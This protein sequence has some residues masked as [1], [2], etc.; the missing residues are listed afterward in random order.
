VALSLTILTSELWMCTFGL[1]VKSR[2]SMGDWVAGEGVFLATHTRLY[3]AL[4][5]VGRHPAVIHTL[6]T[7]Y[8]LPAMGAMAGA[9]SVWRTPALRTDAWTLK[10]VISSILYSSIVECWAVTHVSPADDRTVGS[11]GRCIM[12]SRA[13][14]AST[15]QEDE[16]GAKPCRMTT[17]LLQLPHSLHSQKV[18]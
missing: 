7:F 16:C 5:N 17:H 2:R 8:R 11:W 13:C 12:C 9:R 18:S 1:V 15:A 3:G 10:P 14:V 6:G 4:W